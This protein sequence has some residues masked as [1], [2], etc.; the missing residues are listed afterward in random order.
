M[1][2]YCSFQCNDMLMWYILIFSCF[3]L[4]HSTSEVG[5]MLL[6]LRCVQPQD[7]AMAL[8]L[9]SFSIGLFG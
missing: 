4:I 2:G 3:V 8:G 1:N 6:T 7:K 5:S 9:V